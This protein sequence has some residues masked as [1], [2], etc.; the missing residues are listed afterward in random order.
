[1]ASGARVAVVTN[2]SADH[3]GEYGVHC[4]DDIAS[5]KLVVAKSLA[6]DGVLVLK[7]LDFGVADG[8]IRST[9]RMDARERTIRSQADI[10][11]NGLVLGYGNTPIERI[12]ALVKQLAALIRPR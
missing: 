1:M 10:R 5:V 2:V 3:F 12:D 6:A 4:L 7:P 8:T 11:G 9:I